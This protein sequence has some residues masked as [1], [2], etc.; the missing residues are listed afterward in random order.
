MDKDMTKEP[1]DEDVSQRSKERKITET[2]QKIYDGQNT[3][4]MENSVIKYFY[5]LEYDE[6]VNNVGK[7][8]EIGLDIGPGWGRFTLFLADNVCG[9]VVST[10]LSINRLR[11]IR[12]RSKEAGHDNIYFVQADAKELPF[13]RESFT[14]IIGSQVIGHILDSESFIEELKKV[15]MYNAS[16]ILTFGNIFSFI[17]FRYRWNYLKRNFKIHLS[18]SNFP[19]TCKC[20]FLLIRNVFSRSRYFWLQ[21]RGYHRE[22]PSNIKKMLSKNNFTVYKVSYV[23]VFDAF[24]KIGKWVEFLRHYAPFKY[25]SHLVIIKAIRDNSPQVR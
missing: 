15:A 11:D 7:K 25:L 3:W 17:E 8:Q 4:S 19:E 5:D 1:F 6:I 21:E 20:Y 13:K 18:S 12:R 2:V 9:K 10:D 24:V 16:L 23:G 14:I 22:R